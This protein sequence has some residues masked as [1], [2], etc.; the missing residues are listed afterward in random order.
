MKTTITQSALVSVA[1]C[2][3][4]S[5]CG[6]PS[7]TDNDSPSSPST[8]PETSA[9][10][11]LTGKA[12]EYVAMS[13]EALAERLIFE[14]NG[15]YLDESTQEGGVARDRMT[16]DELQ[17]ICSAGRA[18]LPA[19]MIGEV[20]ALSR[21]ATIK[22]ENGIS[23]GNW[24]AGE[25]VARSG[26]GYR[27]GHNVDDHSNQDPGGN[28]YACHQMAPDEPTYGTLGPSL[29]NFGKLRGD[30]EA[31]RNYLYEVIYSPHSYFP[32][33]NMPRFG[34]NG[35]LTQTQIADVMAYLLDPASPVNQ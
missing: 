27:I 32:C 14:E 3:L 20:V 8:S 15:F 19:D 2:M 33:T 29:V 26:Y 17:K 4:L 9:T 7:S 18:N 35:V 11:G 1:V 28:C 5:A 25:A 10:S 30:T 21:A 24:E 22:P 31:T 23:L 12:A 34:A 16:Q 6:S 13:S